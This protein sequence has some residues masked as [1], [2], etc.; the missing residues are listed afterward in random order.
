MKRLLNASNGKL[1]GEMI[2]AI[3]QHAEE[4]AERMIKD[5]LIP[6]FVEALFDAARKSEGEVGRDK[7]GFFRVTLTNEQRCRLLTRLN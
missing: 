7:A 2:A 4:D 1:T 5:T 3:V 6:A